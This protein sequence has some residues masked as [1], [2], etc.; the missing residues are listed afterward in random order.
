MPKP[1]DIMVNKLEQDFKKNPNLR[2]QI[3]IKLDQ[4]VRKLYTD[5]LSSNAGYCSILKVPTNDILNLY[6]NLPSLE[7]DE[8]SKAFAKQWDVP[9]T[10]HMVNNPFYHLCLLFVTYGIRNN[11][12]KIR[13]KSLTLMLSLL[14]NGRRGRLLPYCDP[15]TMKYV[16]SK[17]T[18]RSLLR[19]YDSPMSL[20][21]DYFIPT[22]IKKYGTMIKR[23][24]TETKRLFDQAFNRMHQIFVRDK[25]P[26]LQ[27]GK[28]EI[29]RGISADYMKA[30]RQ[31]LKITKAQSL[32]FDD[33][34]QS[35]LEQHTTSQYEEII[36]NI[37]N[38]IV[39]NFKPKYEPWIIDHIKR[40][41]KVNERA[42][43][44]FLDN[45]HSIKHNEY[46]R[47]IV[48]LMATRLQVADVNIC[49]KQFIIRSVKEKVISSKNTPDITQMQK[50]IDML[51]E[52]MFKKIAPHVN[53]GSYTSPTRGK[54][55]KVIVYAIAY[56]IQRYMCYK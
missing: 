49:S 5:L 1:I 12:E 26:N 27:T 47:E 29:R 17:L 54:F 14:W 39:M 56:N 28:M 6:N 19:K 34:D 46:I 36:S 32:S 52:E 2:R 8:V 22:L 38:Y 15:D 25:A 10:A 24:S 18:R 48:G 20:I 35:P 37:T 11:N 42:I 33:D 43:R 21:T 40:E 50:I 55:R 51:V 4:S 30:K 16:I 9:P 31:G 45:L 41:S 7:Q 3:E 44:L 13:D 23:D 53:Y